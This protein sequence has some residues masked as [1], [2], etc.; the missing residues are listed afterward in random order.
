M[1]WFEPS[2]VW[3]IA[4]LACLG[5]RSG[6]QAP[7][8]RA[9]ASASAAAAAPS[10][11]PL[12]H[13]KVVRARPAGSIELATAPGPA[14]SGSAVAREVRETAALAMLTDAT[15]ARR[16]PV[17]E[18]EP[19][20]EFDWELRDRVAPRISVPEPRL[21]LGETNA[22]GSLPKEV[23]ARIVRQNFG[24]YRVCAVNSGAPATPTGRVGLTLL[25]GQDGVLQGVND[26]RST[27][28]DAAVLRCIFAATRGLEFPK[29]NGGT[30]ATQFLEFLP[31]EG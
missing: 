27:L 2:G 29:T 30:E 3:A 13:T 10:T 9:S 20:R 24:R 25:I 5:C 23:I 7:S 19:G 22:T 14:P 28:R 26:Y 1:K 17:L 15:L 11:P 4:A 18:L 31:S 21:R 8:P 12:E 6:A 16:M